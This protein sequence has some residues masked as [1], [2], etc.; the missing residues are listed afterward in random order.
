MSYSHKVAV[1]PGITGPTATLW[2][3]DLEMWKKVVEINV[4]GTFAKHDQK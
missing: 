1:G 3:Y 4:M 2:E